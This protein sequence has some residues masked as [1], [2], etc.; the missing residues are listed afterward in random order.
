MFYL[1][2]FHLVTVGQTCGEDR[3]I[4]IVAKSCKNVS[5]NIQ[6]V[7]LQVVEDKMKV[8]IK[9]LHVSSQRRENK[10]CSG[11]VMC[12]LVVLL[13]LLVFQFLSDVLW[14][15]CSKINLNKR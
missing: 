4:R 2:S 6:R 10:T 12:S 3:N 14:T 13:S 7:K 15:K 8:K 11:D 1:H 9:S 5:T